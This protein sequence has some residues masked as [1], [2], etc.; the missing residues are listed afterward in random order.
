MSIS[1]FLGAVLL[2]GALGYL[3]LAAF[4]WRHRQ[5]G[6]GFALV[7]T[8]LAVGVWSICYALELSSRTVDAARLWSGVK[9]L[10]IVALGPALWA[11]VLRYTGRGSLPRWALVLLLVEPVAVLV[12]LAV[13]ATHDLLHYYP[14]RPGELRLLGG[15]PIP[16]IGPLF[17]PHAVYTY[18]VLL[19][20][21]GLLVFRLA[22]V[23]VPY[24]RSGFVLILVALLPFAGNL[25]YNAEIAWPVRVDPTPFL[26]S[27]TMAVL[28]WGFFRLRLLDLLPVA[29][30]VVVDRLADG[31]VVVDAYR[32]FVDANEAAER[33]LGVRRADLVGLTLGE[34]APA[35]DAVLDGHE[36]TLTSRAE[37]VLD[38]PDL[39]PDGGAVDGPE[40]TATG[41][42]LGR[43]GRRSG[44]RSG[45]VPRR[46]RRADV[47]VSVTSITDVV[48]RNTAQV[49][50][51][52]DVSERKRTERRVRELL[53][54]QT[55]LAD[56]L[57]LSLRP[58]TLMEVSG[59]VLAGRSVPGG[60][61]GQVSGDFYDVH[62]AADGRWAFVL[63]DVSGKGVRAAV[64]TS[65]ARYTV[66]TLSAQ[67]WTSPS[68]LSQLNLALA[69]TDDLERFC[70][71]AYAQVESRPEGGLRAYLVLGGHPA[72]LVRR[73]DGLV[74]P[75]G[76]PGTV[77]GT[78]SE[79]EVEVEEVVVDLAPGEILLAYTD[80]VTEARA[81]SELFGEERLVEVLRRAGPGADDVADAVMAAVEVFSIDRDDVA[82]LVVQADPAGAEQARQGK[83]PDG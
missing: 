66:R 63:G 68:V 46:T 23:A 2:V 16:E 15:N 62:A 6:G 36:P 54:E 75:V 37:V 19:G 77:L 24:R 22:Q 82:V 9:Y 56:T 44:G 55:R 32:R 5:A 31:V 60:P 80:G 52:R 57:Q 78:L 4:V 47:A 41:G 81:G 8:L 1:V 27:L 71:V 18:A 26:F 7:A 83:D 74:E 33:L 67:G 79:M 69:T 17:W 64:V 50:V 35:V 53:E 48:G 14:T 42:R 29:R 58:R 65:M 34:L 61:G 40:G 43:L 51:L 20:A 10:G 30:S 49:L 11:F 45:T 13:P 76:V 39:D 72:P 12:V 70:T 3:G 28:V 73:G 38:I 59:A 25:L 21:V